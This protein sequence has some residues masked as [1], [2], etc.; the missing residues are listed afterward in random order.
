MEQ[1][2]SL[3]DRVI[4]LHLQRCSGY[5]PNASSCYHLRKKIDNH[6]DIE[7]D[8]SLVLSCIKSGAIVHDSVCTYYLQHYNWLERYP[9]YNITLS[10][11]LLRGNSE[12]KKFKNQLQ[13]S[14]Y[15]IEDIIE[16]KE[17]QKLFL[18]KDMLSW[19]SFDCWLGQDTGRLHFLLDQAII[20]PSKVEAIVQ[21]F[22]EYAG[23]GQTLD[24][25]LT[26]YL[27]NGECPYADGHYIDLTYD[28]TVRS[29]PYAEKGVRSKKDESIEVLFGIQTLPQRCKYM[30]YFG[31]TLNEK[32]SVESSGDKNT[33]IQDTTGSTIPRG[34]TEYNRG[35]SLWRGWCEGSGD[36]ERA[37]NSKE[38][39]VQDFY[40][41]SD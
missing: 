23:E 32:D 22:N 30:E 10:C 29:C 33:S 14:V 4:S 39:F 16:F 17:Y 36:S 18:I 3:N 5:C 8:A 9:N 15:S 41:G 6:W 34:Y 24:S 28:N 21:D 31:G 40:R 27:V 13:V 25:C 38:G 1:K 20:T 11:E 37:D 12:L 35:L 2:C 26:S 7:E 19:L